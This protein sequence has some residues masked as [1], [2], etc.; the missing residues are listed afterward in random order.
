LRHT[1]SKVPRAWWNEEVRAKPNEIP[2]N[3]K[4]RPE[5]EE[6][7]AEEVKCSSTGAGQIMV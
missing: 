1:E 7:G 2:L 3:A 5:N 6:I 4:S